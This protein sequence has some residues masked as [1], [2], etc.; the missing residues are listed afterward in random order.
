MTPIRASFASIARFSRSAL[1]TIA[2][3]SLTGSRTGG[4]FQH[5]PSIPLHEPPQPLVDSDMRI[6]PQKA[7]G[8]G[9]VGEGPVDVPGGDL[10][11]VDRGLPAGGPLQRRHQSRQANRLRLTEIDDFE[12]LAPHHVVESGHDTVHD[13]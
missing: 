9:D 1:S 5:H 12:G 7:A 13:I 10:P 3:L 2:F 6:V 8:T 11:P 4:L